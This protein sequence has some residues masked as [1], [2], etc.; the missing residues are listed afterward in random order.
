MVQQLIKVA[1]PMLDEHG[2]NTVVGAII[3]IC[4]EDHLLIVPDGE[5]T[6]NTSSVLILVTS[7][8]VLLQTFVLVC[9]NYH[10]YQHTPT[11]TLN[12][13]ASCRQHHV[14]GVGSDQA[15]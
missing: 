3:S 1:A 6:C 7:G 14:T 4:R 15:P 11:L 5:V 8:A 12:P 10:R 13:D 2:W 9:V